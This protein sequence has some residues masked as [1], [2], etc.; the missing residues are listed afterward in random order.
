MKEYI[1]GN[2]MIKNKK[3]ETNRLLI[4]PYVESDLNDA[5]ELMQEKE[6]F[7]YLPMDVMSFD[8]YKELFFWLID[9]YDVSHKDN[10][11]KY[12][13]S[14]NLKESGMHIGWCGV[15]SLDYNH[16]DIEVFYLIGKPF[17]SNGYATEAMNGL[18]N[19]CFNSLQLQRISAVVKPENVSSKK[20]LEK[21]GLKQQYTVNGLPEKFDFYNGEYYYSINKTWSCKAQEWINTKKTKEY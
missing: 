17:W 5:F 4:R 9:C 10:W 20:V 16:S 13:F 6:L 19:Y 1:G 12:S 11:F 15:G 21:L 7:K 3:I 2:F 18:I 14:I 8:E